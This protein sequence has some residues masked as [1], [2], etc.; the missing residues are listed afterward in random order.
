VT[1][2]LRRGAATLVVTGVVALSGCASALPERFYT[3]SAQG[4]PNQQG[5]DLAVQSA[6]GQD[7]SVAISAVTIPGTLDRPQMVRFVGDGR[8]DLT[9]QER[10]GEPLAHGIAR[11][12]AEDLRYR[13]GVPMVAAYPQ[14]ASAHARFRI[15][16][17]FTHLDART[18]DVLLDAI[19][20]VRDTQALSAA[21][22]PG[23]QRG[24]PAGSQSNLQSGSQST[25]QSGRTV[26]TESASG[27]GAEGAVLA[28]SAALARLADALASAVKQLELPH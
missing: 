3:L 11:T 10:W 13:L 23:P 16:V 25:S 17:D 18:G 21:V 22:S 6:S 19:W 9:E 15:T 20:T 28:E 2:I 12:L 27:V 26:L 7:L 5:T 14:D 1:S 4:A 24:L 8:V